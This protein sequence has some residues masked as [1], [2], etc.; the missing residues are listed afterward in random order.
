[1]RPEGEQLAIRKQSDRHKILE[2][3][4]IEINGMIDIAIQPV[5]DPVVVKISFELKVLDYKNN[6]LQVT[7]D[8]K[9][10]GWIT[11]DSARV[12]H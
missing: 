3:P 1:M 5:I 4:G 8:G 2:I 9:S 12:I 11:N 6:W 7:P 10:I